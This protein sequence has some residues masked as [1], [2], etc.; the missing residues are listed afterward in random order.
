MSQDTDANEYSLFHGGPFYELQRRLRLVRQDRENSLQRAAVFVALAWAVPLLLSFYEGKAWG[1]FAD[2]PYLLHLTAW[3]RFFVCVG[4]FVLMEPFV[5]Q[6][7]A[8]VLRRL[9][10]SNLLAPGSEPAAAA[11]IKQAL[12]RSRKFSAELTCFLVAAVLSSLSA[13]VVLD[14]NPKSWVLHHGI[15][16]TSLSLAA[17]WS[18]IVSAPIF[19]FLLARWAWRLIVWGTLL[20]DLAAL[21]LRLVVTH[22]DGYGGIGF[23]G[24]YPNAYTPFIF[25]ISCNT[26]ATVAELLIRGTMGGASYVYVMIGWLIIVHATISLPLFTFSNSLSELKRKTLERCGVQATRYQ[27]AVERRVLGANIVATSDAETTQVGEIP[28][29]GALFAAA[30]KMSTF[31]FNRATLL[32]VSAAALAPLVAA[33]ATQIPIE[34]LLKALKR[35]LLI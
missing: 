20:R 16:R 3:A 17:W 34:T 19:Y 1:P 22:P 27:R 35:L 15:D 6:R 28:D 11:A 24:E 33:G 25:A 30:K 4:I 31:L 5:G 9:L 12:I 14:A 10:R 18:L 2:R 21:N 26:G 32:P 8:A 23:V 7:L 13:L 29:P